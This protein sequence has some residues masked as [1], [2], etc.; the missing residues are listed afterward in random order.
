MALT[1]LRI[2][3]DR[4]EYSRFEASRSTVRARV[5][6]GPA[7]V[8]GDEEVVV[9][10]RRKSGIE[11]SRQTITFA[12]GD[13][14]KGQI[15]EFDLAGICD[16]AGTPIC[17]RGD[18]YIN[19]E[20]G[21]LE[22][23]SNMFRVSMI[24]VEWFKSSY[25]SGLPLTATEQLV[26]VKQPS[27]VT[28]VTVTR[29][30][31][32]TRPGLKAIVYD[33]ALN[34]LTYD[35]GPAV[36]IGGTTEILP[37][38]KGDYIEVAIDEFDLPSVD[39]SEA[40]LIDKLSISNEMIQAQI[41]SAISDVEN[42]LLKIFVEPMRIATEPFFDAP[43]PG[44][45]YDRKVSSLTYYAKDFNMQALAWHLNLPLHQLIS[46][47]KIEGWMGNSKALTIGSGAL[48]CNRKAGMVDVLPYNSQYS[49]FYTF[50]IQLNFWGPREY[51][52]NFWRYTGKAGIETA[53]GDIL[54]LI[55]YTAAIPVLT[56]AGQAARAG[57]NSES[58]SKDGVS[59]SASYNQQG[60]Y[61]AAITEYKA[62]TKDNIPRLG[63]QYRGM[64]MVVL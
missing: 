31:E 49:A 3:T 17:A 18:Y 34:S 25:C 1:S 32:R 46:L 38:S 57:A 59:R 10:L 35:N 7:A 15:V 50:L 13:H 26:P 33:Q 12:V 9:T 51:I 42:N 4:S 24:T 47:D 48:A 63:R 2:V 30:S 61:A 53:G 16:A 23:A 56:A 37:G 45:W 52:A 11:M 14:P 58:I 29:V 8:T 27:V 19:A 55:G 39:A 43:D 40:I 41:D 28:G 21:S 64:S 6:P 54:K 36:T 62:W 5:I 20:Q 22:A 44:E 60:L